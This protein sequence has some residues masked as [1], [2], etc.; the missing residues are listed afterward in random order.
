MKP[1][2]AVIAALL[3]ALA[4]RSA[5]QAPS[6]ASCLLVSNVFAKQ[7]TDPNQKA[8]A[9]N[10]LFY[11]FGR[12][13]GRLSESQLKDALKAAGSNPLTAQ[14]VTTLMNNCARNMET[15]GQ[16][17]QNISQQLQKA[18]PKGR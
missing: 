12:L 17:L 10:V 14:S 3:V 16:S 4:G 8:R 6:D 11:Y 2:Y 13:D 9:Q 15:R 7:S 1:R 18:P 5:A